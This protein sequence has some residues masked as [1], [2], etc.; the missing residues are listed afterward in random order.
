MQLSAGLKVSKTRCPGSTAT[1][2]PELVS[3]LVSGHELQLTSANPE[4]SWQSWEMCKRGSSVPPASKKGICTCSML[5]LESPSQ[6]SRFWGGRFGAPPLQP[7][8]VS[9]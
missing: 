8:Q 1:S 7:I 3:L 4:T 9:R 6:V 5:V 2:V